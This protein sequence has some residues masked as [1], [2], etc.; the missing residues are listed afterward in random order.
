M[1]KSNHS[2][3]MDVSDVRPHHHTGACPHCSQGSHA[4]VS[5]TDLCF[6]SA[7]VWVRVEAAQKTHT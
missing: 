2:V 6:S 3:R 1:I 4:A 5:I 7:S